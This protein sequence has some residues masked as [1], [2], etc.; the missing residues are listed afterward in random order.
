MSFARRD[1]IRVVTRP[2]KRDVISHPLLYGVASLL[3]T[4][5]QFESCS[6][7]SGLSTNGVHI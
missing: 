7:E 5:S 4:G 6:G 2:E 3:D 1:A